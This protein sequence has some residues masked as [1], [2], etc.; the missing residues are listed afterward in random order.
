M[1]APV[2]VLTK[3]PIFA[4]VALLAVIGACGAGG[5]GGAPAPIMGIPWS[6]SLLFLNELALKGNFAASS[7]ALAAPGASNVAWVYPLLVLKICC[8]LGESVFQPL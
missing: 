8:A 1:V 4:A 5:A 6:R 7:L 3:D 2:I